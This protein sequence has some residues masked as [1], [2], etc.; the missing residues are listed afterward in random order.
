MLLHSFK[1]QTITWCII[2]TSSSNWFCQFNWHVFDPLTM[3]LL[4]N[5]SQYFMLKI[6]Q[7]KNTKLNKLKSEKKKKIKRDKPSTEPSI[8]T[9]KNHE[10]FII[11]DENCH[12]LI[13][14]IS[15]SAECWYSSNPH[16]EW[17]KYGASP[18]DSGIP[19]TLSPGLPWT[20]EDMLQPTIDIPRFVWRKWGAHHSAQAIS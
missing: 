4:I 12:E 2:L 3:L 9:A 19:K 20:R 16:F 10:L 5:R 14:G 18:I 8:C 1:V 13:L 11:D 7:V 15:T 17:K 6:D